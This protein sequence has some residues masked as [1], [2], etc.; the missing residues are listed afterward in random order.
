MK[1]CCEPFGERFMLET[2]KQY[3]NKWILGLRNDL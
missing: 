2:I 3:K 1:F